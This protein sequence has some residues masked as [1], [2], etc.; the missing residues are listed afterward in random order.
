M[1]HIVIRSI[2]S[3]VWVAVAVYSLANG[4]KL[5]ALTYGVIGVVFGINAWKQYK[6]HM[7]G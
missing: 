5:M 1:R 2:M 4:D 7:K 3:L 6:K